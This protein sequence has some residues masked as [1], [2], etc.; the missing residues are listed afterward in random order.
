MR[1]GGNTGNI[2]CTLM[3]CELKGDKSS[4]HQRCLGN[5]ENWRRPILKR[6]GSFKIN[7][8]NY[9]AKEA[10]SALKLS[11]LKWSTCYLKAMQ[12]PESLLQQA[13]VFSGFY[14]YIYI[15]LFMLKDLNKLIFLLVLCRVTLNTWVPVR[16]LEG[17]NFSTH[18]SSSLY[19]LMSAMPLAIIKMPGS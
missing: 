12:L 2:P 18:F 13:S 19:L 11:M 8:V 17:G 7:V 3:L 5:C 1:N 6:V 10:I 15:L 4:G 16:S 14:T 9:G